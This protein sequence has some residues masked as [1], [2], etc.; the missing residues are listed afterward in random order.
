MSRRVTAA[1]AAPPRPLGRVL[2][3]RSPQWGGAVSLQSLERGNGGDTS[4]T[5]AGHGLKNHFPI[6][7]G[8]FSLVSGQVYAVDGVSFEIRRG[9]TLGLVG[10]SG[11]GKSAGGR[12]LLKLLEPTAGTIRVD[13]QDI[14]RLEGE[15]LL[16]Y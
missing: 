14:T 5:V 7:K 3:C 15:A 2:A 1:G 12:P 9:E 13:G 6:H 10:E 8:V 16:P 11:G 4:H